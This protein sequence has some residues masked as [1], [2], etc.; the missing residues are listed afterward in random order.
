M[1]VSSEVNGR[2]GRGCQRL[3][4]R[5]RGIPRRTLCNLQRMGH[6]YWSFRQPIVSSILG[7]RQLS[8]I[9]EDRSEMLAG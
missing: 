5:A 4:S 3:H 8:G 6:V 9:W 7:R 2:G 1:C